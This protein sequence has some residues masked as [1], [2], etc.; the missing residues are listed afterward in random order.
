LGERLFFNLVF[1]P[2]L[3]VV[4]CIGLVLYAIG[5]LVVVAGMILFLI[6]LSPYILMLI[7][8]LATLSMAAE[9]D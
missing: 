6:Y 9:R 1:M 2:C 7:V 5:W 4:G 3:W 8:I